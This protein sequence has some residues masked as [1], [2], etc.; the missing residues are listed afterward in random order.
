MTLAS[1]SFFGDE[2]GVVS[3]TTTAHV[4]PALR[5]PNGGDLLVD[6][7]TL[8]VSGQTFRVNY[9]TVTNIASNFTTTAFLTHVNTT[10]AFQ[11]RTLTRSIVEGEE[12]VL[13]GVITEPDTLDTFFLDVDWGDG[14]LE[15]LSFPAGTDPNLALRHRYL[16]D[17][18]YNVN[19]AWHDQHNTGLR[20]SVE[21]ITVRNA[22]PSFRN[23]TISSPV[24]AG[25]IVALRGTLF[26]RGLND[27]LRLTIR[28]GD[29][30]GRQ[31]VNI[32][33]G[34]RDFVINHQFAHRGRHWITLIASDES[35]HAVRHFLLAIVRNAAS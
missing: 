12:A 2:F 17:G 4:D 32:A 5:G 22:L 29:G 3:V 34:D 24:A 19:L 15:N 25:A 10:P 11:N 26:D 31:E 7:S 18:N 1:A 9:R 30:T 14:T 23:V 6:G 28:W 27:N 35:G 33:A 8:Q 20:T 21:K 13:R 16:K